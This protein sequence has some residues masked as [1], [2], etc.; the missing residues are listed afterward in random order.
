VLAITQGGGQRVLAR[1]RSI[2]TPNHTDGA[3]DLALVRGEL[4]V[5]VSA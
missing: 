4:Y 5:A 3:A 1:V 2:G